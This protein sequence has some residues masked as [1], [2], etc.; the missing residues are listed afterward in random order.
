MAALVDGLL[1]LDR[2]L[3]GV[4]TTYPWTAILSLAV[5]G[6]LISRSTQTTSEFPIVNDDKNDWTSL[7]MKKE[8]VTN[9][10][11]LLAEG[12]RKVCRLQTWEVCQKLG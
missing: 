8:Y 12:H 2:S 11:K 3:F 7:G 6:W 4:Q 10:K 1:G 9:A 5:I